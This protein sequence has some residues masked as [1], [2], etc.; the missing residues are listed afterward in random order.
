MK[1]EA[2]WGRIIN[3]I[4]ESGYIDDAGVAHIPS[5]IPSVFLTGRGMYDRQ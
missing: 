4:Y 5:A 3:H 2:N 1:T